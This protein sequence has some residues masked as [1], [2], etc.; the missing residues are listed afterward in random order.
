[1]EEDKN[2]KKEFS[3]KV[4]IQSLGCNLA[5]GNKKQKTRSINNHFHMPRYVETNKREVA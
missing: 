1:M 4:D 2:K 5:C 3:D